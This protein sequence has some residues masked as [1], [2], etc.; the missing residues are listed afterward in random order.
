M[1]RQNLSRPHSL[2]ARRHAASPIAFSVISFGPPLL[3]ENLC[4]A[5]LM[6][7]L[8][9][10]LVDRSQVMREWVSRIA[11]LHPGDEG[12]EEWLVD[13][14][15]D[16]DAVRD[17]RVFLNSVRTRLGM[18]DSVDELLQRWPNE[19]GG[20]YR[21]DE[22]TRDALRSTRRRGIPVVIVGATAAESVGCSRSC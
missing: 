9:D 3:L 17:R 16:G 5:V 12:L 15:C 8:D 10:T 4:M 19:F 1:V 2:D 6:V 14:D 13:W 11:K 21:L 20:H 18:T 7:D 22:A